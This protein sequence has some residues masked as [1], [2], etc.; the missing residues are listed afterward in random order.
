MFVLLF[1]ILM[2]KMIFKIYWY[3]LLYKD[4]FRLGFI[5]FEKGELI[6]NGRICRFGCCFD[7][8]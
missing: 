7:L 3:F 5:E 2:M 1:L 4:V 6:E 8:R